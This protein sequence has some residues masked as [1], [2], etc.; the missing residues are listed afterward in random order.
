M[1]EA[2]V[3]C[4]GGRMRVRARVWVRACACRARAGRGKGA[5]QEPEHVCQPQVFEPRLRFL[6]LSGASQAG[7]KPRA[8]CPGFAQSGQSLYM[9]IST[10][11]T[12]L[13]IK[14][15]AL[16]KIK[17]TKSQKSNEEPFDLQNSTPQR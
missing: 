13:T 9:F 3:R 6:Y 4:E 2:C 15:M 1:A 16:V 7:N 14:T 5:G 8:G 10:D 11:K 12:Y 17:E